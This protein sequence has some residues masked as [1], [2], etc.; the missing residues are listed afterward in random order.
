[1]VFCWDGRGKT[2]RHKLG[3]TGYKAN[4]KK[5]TET[6][7]VHKQEA[8]LKALLEVM[9]FWTPE[10]EGVEGDDLLGVLSGGWRGEKEIRVYS[11]DK[12]MF[13]LVG[14]GVT[15]WQSWK[16]NPMGVQEVMNRMG[17]EPRN[18]TEIRAMAGDSADNLKGL[19][20][21]GLKTAVKLYHLGV[22]PS[23]TWEEM[24]PEAQ[25]AA[26]KWKQDWPRIWKEYQLALIPRSPTAPC[27]EEKQKKELTELVQDIE[28]SPER[29]ERDRQTRRS[30]WLEFLGKYEFADLWPRKELVWKIP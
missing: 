4:R 14:K 6:E 25:V 17:M 29:R 11:G 19:R 9:G 23:Q 30:A 22:R 28:G 26:L 5:T 8:V 21:V 13:Q 10:V 16:E 3:N 15:V 7:I 27:W 18:L 20:K 1:M 2:W 24:L 12:D